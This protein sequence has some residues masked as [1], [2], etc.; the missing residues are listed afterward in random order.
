MGAVSL[1][2]GRARAHLHTYLGSARSKARQTGSGI[3]RP[4]NGSFPEFQFQFQ[5][6][7]Q[8]QLQLQLQFQLQFQFPR[9]EGWRD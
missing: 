7:L 3:F 6:Q 9:P 1:D 4:L 2:S 5:F 8:L